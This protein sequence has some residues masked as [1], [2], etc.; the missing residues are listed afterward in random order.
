MLTRQIRP[1]SQKKKYA[2]ARVARLHCYVGNEN[3]CNSDVRAS[4]MTSSSS[5]PVLA[6]MYFLGSRQ[7][8]KITAADI[9]VFGC[10]YELPTT[11]NTIAKTLIVLPTAGNPGC[12][13][14]PNASASTGAALTSWYCPYGLWY[15]QIS[16]SGVTPSIYVTALAPNI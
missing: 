16:L 12:I 1:V 13:C 11:S 10:S 8:A 15:H 2:G 5:K 4:F 3:Q 7:Q 14:C 9:N 6:S